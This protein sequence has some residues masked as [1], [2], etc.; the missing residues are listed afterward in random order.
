MSGHNQLIGGVLVTNRQDLFDQM[1]YVQKTIGAVSSPFDCWL[2]LMGLK[3]L[4]L[5][6]ARHAE[7]AGKVAAYLEAHPKIEQ[8]LY[9]GLASHPQHEL[10][11]E[12]MSGFSGMISFELTGGTEA[13]RRLMNGVKLFGLAESLGSVETMITHCLLYTSPS[14]RDRG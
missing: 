12:Q 14:P 1:K 6:M 8:V 13:G 2:N 10:A 4:H 7:T 3:T 11:K 5:R 9:P